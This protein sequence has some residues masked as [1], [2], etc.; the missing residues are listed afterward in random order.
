MARIVRKVS[1]SPGSGWHD[2]PWHSNP[3]VDAFCRSAV[4][5]AEV[6]SL[7]LP[8]LG[9]P[10]WRSW[11]QFACGPASEDD[12]VHVNPCVDRME[13]ETEIVGVG[14]P[15]GVAGWAPEDRARMVLEVIRAGMGR[16]GASR[17]WE[18]ALLQGLYADTAARGLE[19]AA[20]SPWKSS[21]DRR[22]QARTVHRVGPDGLE[23]VR[24]EVCDRD[25]TVVATSGDLVAVSRFGRLTWTGSERVAVT[26]RAGRAGES[27]VHL[28]RVEGS[29]HGRIVDGA[30]HRLPLAGAEARPGRPLPDVVVSGYGV[31]A[32]ERPP[33]IRA[34]GG[35]PTNGVS[36]A[37][38]EAVDARLRELADEAGQA[39]W[40]DAGMKELDAIYHF[41]PQP[42]V[43]SRR[44]GQRLRAE[45]RRPA[46]TTHEDP[47][48]LAASDVRELVAEIRR[49]TGLG[50]HPTL[51]D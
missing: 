2:Q 13:T 19:H 35:G 7:G 47:E 25:G 36:A 39:W 20:T 40:Q 1:V 15:A 34:G 17:G 51:R 45:I 42:A 9:L 33:I 6:Y 12:C 4:S 49:K 32:P 11:V 5:V 14:L 31:D 43:W 26:S 46:A 28:A 8:G 22:H 30:P 16:L 10:A 37:Y 18:S 27:G 29:W 38:L 24:I 48:G 23:R 3:D 44:S 21:P 41:G 50:P